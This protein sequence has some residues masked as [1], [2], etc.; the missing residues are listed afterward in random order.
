VLGRLSPNY[1]GAEIEGVVKSAL[2]FAV[3]RQ[4][5]QPGPV[6]LSVS[7]SVC[8]HYGVRRN[9]PAR[10][11]EQ[12]FTGQVRMVDLLRG[13]KDVKPHYGAG[14]QVGPCALTR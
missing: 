11:D 6:P 7:R 3:Q 13:L 12:S 4:V 10:A 2:S 9:R 8:C 14:G 5:S 1:T